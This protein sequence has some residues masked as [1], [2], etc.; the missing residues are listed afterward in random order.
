MHDADAVFAVCPLFAAPAWQS[1]QP[2]SV[3][4]LCAKAAGFT[5]MGFPCEFTMPVSGPWQERHSSAAKRA[6]HL[7]EN[8]NATIT[9]V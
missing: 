6:G 9:T 4:T 3:C 5:V 8:A 2:K 7:V 1:T